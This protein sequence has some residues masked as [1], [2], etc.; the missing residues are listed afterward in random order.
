MYAHVFRDYV[1]YG[2]KME[3]IT[4]LFVT[5]YLQL[6]RAELSVRVGGL[7]ALDPYSEIPSSSVDPQPKIDRMS[8][9]YRLH[10]VLRCTYVLGQSGVIPSLGMRRDLV[11][12][13][14]PE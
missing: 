4:T 6:A 1:T 13:G 5:D 11:V 12:R 9:R 7:L 2:R 8:I 14:K 3:C 10:A